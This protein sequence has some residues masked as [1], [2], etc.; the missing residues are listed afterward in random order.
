MLSEI[1]KVNGTLIVFTCALL[2]CFLLFGASQQKIANRFFAGFLLLLSIDVLAWA[3][4]NPIFFEGWLGSLRVSLGLLQMPLYLGFIMATLF[5]QFRLKWWYAFHGLPFFIALLFTIKG[6]Q[7]LGSHALQTHEYL[8]SSE[9]SLISI[10][11]GTQYYLYIAVAAY[12]LFQF[13]RIFHAHYSG[14]Q[15]LTFKWLCCLVGVSLAAH[16]L[17]RAKSFAATPETENI[18][19]AL[20]LLMSF[21]TLFVVSW[22]TLSA[23][24]LPDLFRAV[25]RNLIK[26]ASHF[27]ENGQPQAAGNSDLKLEVDQFM[28]I[29]QPFLEHDLTLHDLAKL[30]EISQHKLSIVLNS[31][32]G[33]TF[34]NF[35]NRYRVAHAQTILLDKPSRGISDILGDVGFSSKSSFN[36]AFRKNTGTTP[37]EY[38]K[39]RLNAG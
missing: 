29:K 35:V 38:R 13:R 15:S 5:S 22:F 18:F 16:V 1:V 8:V 7:F 9:M 12:Y 32:F 20:Q 10:M 34:F 6:N 11:S 26:V 4:Y 2:S 33:E 14:S 25:D 36:T 31:E 3:I 39:S 21:T 30:L 19:L 23:L 37:S 27:S 28:Q 17:V 24:L